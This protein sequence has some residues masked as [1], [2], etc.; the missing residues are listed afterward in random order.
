MSQC[1]NFQWYHCWRTFF[2]GL[3]GGEQGCINR[4]AFVLREIQHAIIC[5][6]KVWYFQGGVLF[7][8]TGCMGERKTCQGY[9]YWGE[10]SLPG[11]CGTLFCG[12]ISL[13]EVDWELA[14]TSWYSCCIVF[15][16]GI[17]VSPHGE[18]ADAE[19]LLSPS[20]PHRRSRTAQWSYRFS[21]DQTWVSLLLRFPLPVLVKVV[22]VT[23]HALNLQSEL[24]KKTLLIFGSLWRPCLLTVNTK[25]DRHLEA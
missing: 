1:S 16:A 7:S 15:S 3:G 13:Y 19:A 23:A 25:N 17:T 2:T 8:K 6:L 10:N 5:V 24:L 20:P 18:A 21:S 14:A 12:W 9:L 11:N 22:Q 4:G